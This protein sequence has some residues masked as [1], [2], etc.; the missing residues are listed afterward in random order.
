MFK[1]ENWKEELF[2][3]AKMCHDRF[4]YE[5]GVEFCCN[6]CELLTKC[7]K[8]NN[9]PYTRILKEKLMVEYKAWLKER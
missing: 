5:N 8:R 7:L 2:E 6:G 3:R 9:T 4:K 1:S